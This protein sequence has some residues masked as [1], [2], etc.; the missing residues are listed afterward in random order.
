M[1]AADDFKSI[2]LLIFPT[3][4]IGSSSSHRKA[5]RNRVLGVVGVEIA[6]DHCARGWR[7]VSIDGV[8]ILY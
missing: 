8:D 3:K 1:R 5:L 4:L 7:I 6:K 2:Y